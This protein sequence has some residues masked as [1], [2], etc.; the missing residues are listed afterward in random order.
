M[1]YKNL[2]HVTKLTKKTHTHFEY[3][4]TP[5]CTAGFRSFALRRTKDLGP[6]LRL[7]SFTPGALVLFV[8]FNQ[9]TALISNTKSVKPQNQILNQTNL[10]FANPPQT[11]PQK[12]PTF[13]KVVMASSGSGRPAF[14]AATGLSAEALAAK[15]LAAVI[16][17][18]A[19]LPRERCPGRS[20]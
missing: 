6:T 8:S 14:V 2:Q 11:K 9:T 5:R 16:P 10:L 13:A 15:V 20:G 18:A 19:E 12:P 7:Q 4:F 17:D 3:H 1:N